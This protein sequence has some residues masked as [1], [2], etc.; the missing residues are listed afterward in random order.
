MKRIREIKIILVSASGGHFEQL[1]GLFPLK[2]KYSCITITE[3][4]RISDKADYYFLQ[5]GNKDKWVYIK[6]AG[7][8]LKALF[9]WLNE[10]PTHIISTGTIICLPFFLLAKL[11]GA[12]TIFIETFAR[13]SDR[14]KTGSFIYERHLADLFIVQWP[15]LLGAYP[16]AI[17]GGSLY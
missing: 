8:F 4:T 11:F 10:R 12:K 6:L 17:Y 5:T 2:E 3:R 15:S 13:V 1:K 9:I 7:M 14:T 16:N